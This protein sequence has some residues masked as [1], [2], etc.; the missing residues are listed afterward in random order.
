MNLARFRARSTF[1]GAFVVL[2]A[3]LAALVF[4]DRSRAAE[5]IYWNN[6]SGD[7]DSIGYAG[8]DGSGGGALNLSGAE[9]KGP[10]GMA[11]DSVTNRLFV[12]NAGSNKIV[13]INLDG[14]GAADFNPPGAP[15]IDP[16]GLVVDPESRTVYWINAEP[17]T[18]SWARLDG[19]AGGVVDTGGVSVDAYRLT[20]DPVA[21]RLYWFDESVDPG[22][23]RYAELNSVGS[24]VV[25]ISGASPS[26]SASG[27]AVEP[28]LGKVFWL[29]NSH[30]L[31]S[32]ASLSGSGGGDLPVVENSFFGPYGLVVDAALNRVYWANYSHG[33]TRTGALGFL[34]LAGGGAAIDVP[35][36]PVDG[37]QDPIVL[38]SP[39]ATQAPSITRAK[40]SRAMLSCATGTWAADAVGAFLY[41]APRSFAYQ[42]AKNGKQ[43]AGATATT[44]TAKSA[45]KYT[46][47]V[48]ATNQSGATASTSA[49]VK[50]KAAKL[51]LTTKAKV[52]AR[53]GGLV[54]FSV[55]AANLGDLKSGKAK[56]CVKLA[57]AAKAALEAPKCKSLGK[58]AGA[59]KKTVKLELK[60]LTS[61]ASGTYKLTFQVKGASGKG[62]KAK[63]VV[64]D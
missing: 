4:A 9:L 33:E 14:S 1:G 62:A 35:T 19:S 30:S 52:G 25:N 38:K 47:I 15:I 43:L 56:V 50:V 24:G 64:S 57:G 44:L 27:I 6:Y 41:Q 17:D 22:V 48:T 26:N 21:K 60:V 53:P 32:W 18:I 37:P 39:T 46:C 31:V 61:A 3:L 49:G 23:V 7:P 54:S 12:A 51:K 29:N 58:L 36:A 34:S 8:I 11:Y 63:V 5:T 40:G 59:K 45:A 13:A 28:Q 10:E 20:M 55:K 16:D 42:W 2:F